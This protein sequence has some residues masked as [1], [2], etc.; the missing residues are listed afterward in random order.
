MKKNRVMI[1]GGRKLTDEL[2]PSLHSAGYE[3]LAR[4]LPYFDV[5]DVRDFNPDVVIIDAA[6]DDV[7]PAIRECFLSDVVMRHIPFVVLG[8][9]RSYARFLC[10]DAFVRAPFASADAVTEAVGSLLDLAPSSADLS[11]PSAL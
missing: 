6:E 7:V 2:I 9:S 1:L 4:D 5:L 11:V 3:L 10:A 8:R